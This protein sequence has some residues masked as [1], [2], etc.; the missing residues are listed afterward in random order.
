MRVSL[1][2]F[3]SAFLTLRWVALCFGMSGSGRLVEESSG[4]GLRGRSNRAIGLSASSF[5]LLGDVSALFLKF[6]ACSAFVSELHCF[7]D[8]VAAFIAVSDASPWPAV[9]LDV[10][11]L[12]ACNVVPMLVEIGLV[13]TELPDVARSHNIGGRS[14]DRG[15]ASKPYLAAALWYIVTAWD[16]TDLGQ[17]VGAPPVVV[18]P[19]RH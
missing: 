9:P 19:P 10:G 6:K 7:N 16:D 8:P 3:G 18:A 2:W 12:R 15:I 14:S 11:A 5:L 17:R 1:C 4:C 13:D